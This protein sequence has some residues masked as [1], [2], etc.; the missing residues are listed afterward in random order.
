[1]AKTKSPAK[2]KSQSIKKDKF[3]EK[4]LILNKW[5]ISLFE[6]DSFGDL[7]KDIKKKTEYEKV[8][9]G[10]SRY[11]Q[12][13]C[14]Q[15]EFQKGHLSHE[16]IRQ[17]DANIVTHTE[18]ISHKRRENLHWKYFQ[19]LTLLFTEIYLDRFFRDPEGLLND[20]NTFLAGYNAD[21]STKDQVPE[22]KNED[23][24]K[25]AF[26]SATG[27]GKTLIMHMHILQ[28]QHYL[29]SAW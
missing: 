28:Y 26:W 1:M 29:V 5:M 23:L 7:C 10:V 3:D 25:L 27:S 17:Y 16:F 9:E 11:A 22:Y 21:K 24:N 12:A 18:K 8:D 14:L 19:Y 2:A 4:K 20:L 6:V 13:I 15:F